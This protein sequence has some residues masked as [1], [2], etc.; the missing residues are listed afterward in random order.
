MINKENNFEKGINV[1]HKEQIMVDGVDVSGCKNFYCG[2]CEEENKIPRT[3]NHLTADCRMYPNCDYKQLKRKEQE[4]EQKEKEL[5]S[6]EKIIN[7]L[8]KEVDELKQEYEELEEKLN[9]QFAE[10]E[11][12]L[13]A[14]EMKNYELKEKLRIVS[15]SVNTFNCSRARSNTGYI[16]ITYNNKHNLYQ[17]CIAKDGKTYRKP[18]TKDLETAIRYKQELEMELYGEIRQ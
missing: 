11:E 18:Y 8:M 15:R 4:C 10:M 2:I 9:A 6:N 3:I 13:T 7:K 14:E 1:L 5:L 16:G 17:V 12:K